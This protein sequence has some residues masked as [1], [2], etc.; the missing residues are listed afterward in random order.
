MDQTRTASNP[1]AMKTLDQP[2]LSAAWQ[3]D[4]SAIYTGGCDKTVRI[5]L[6]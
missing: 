3:G 5:T 1:K 4:G 6:T 2:V